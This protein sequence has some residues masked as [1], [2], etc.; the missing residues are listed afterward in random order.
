MVVLKSSIFWDITP[1]NPLKVNRR[2]G[3][4]CGLYLTVQERAK[5]E[6]SFKQVAS[7]VNATHI[8]LGYCL[9]YSSVLKMV[10]VSSE[11]TVHFQRTKRRYIPEDRAR[12][13]DTFLDY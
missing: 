3:G 11:T 13:I 4:I 8:L 7:T 12:Q 9:A 2:F 6:A 5:Q 1:R 10:T